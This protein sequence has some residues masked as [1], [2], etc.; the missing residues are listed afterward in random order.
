MRAKG[1]MYPTEGFA[2]VTY[3][4]FKKFHYGQEIS[5]ITMV[6]IILKI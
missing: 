4:K 3:K 6:A 2:F 1:A 5:H